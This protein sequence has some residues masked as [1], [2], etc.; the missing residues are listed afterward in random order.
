MLLVPILHL[1]QFRSNI[2]HHQRQN[3]GAGHLLKAGSSETG[4]VFLL[5]PIVYIYYFQG[6]KA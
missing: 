5:L 3:H 4:S 6:M 1:Y 2:T